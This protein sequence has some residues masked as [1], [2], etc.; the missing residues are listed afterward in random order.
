MEKEHEDIGADNKQLHG[1]TREFFMN[2]LSRMHK[3]C[4]LTDL[5]V[6]NVELKLLGNARSGLLLSGMKMELCQRLPFM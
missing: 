4:E 3:R 2:A 6:A 5:K 1:T